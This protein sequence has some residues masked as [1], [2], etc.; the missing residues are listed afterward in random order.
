MTATVAEPDRRH[1]AHLLNEAGSAL[2]PD[3]VAAL[4]AGVLAA[5][6]ETGTSWHALVA[7]PTPPA[8]AE[9]LEATRAH[10][11]EDYHDG[12]GREDFPP[13]PRPPPVPFPPQALKPQPPTPSPPTPP[14]HPPA[15]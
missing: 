4:V 8:L 15:Q 11:A 3:G 5:P 13:L 12:I 7:D 2:D 1:L 14:P 10:L 9:A 6:P